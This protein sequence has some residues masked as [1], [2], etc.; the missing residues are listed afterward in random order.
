MAHVAATDLAF[1]HPGGDT[2][3]SGV[4]F[5]VSDGAHV[6]VVGANGVG[7]ST[8]FRVV[9]GLLPAADGDVRVGGELA[10]MPQDVGLGGARDGETV[11]ELLLAAAPA[12]VADAGRRMLAAER[13]LAADGGDA[14]AGMR[15]GEAMADWSELGGYE[16]EGRWDAAC[17]RIVRAGLDE[18]GPRPVHALSGG[19]RKQLVLELLLASEAQ[20][21]L[22]DEPDNFLDIPAKRWLEH[23]IAASKKTILLISHDRDLLGAVTTGVLTLEGHGCWMHG[24][25]FRTYA[26]AREHRQQ[27][28]GD[29]LARW[30]EEER[31]LFHYYKT[32][33][34]R[35]AI[36]EALARRADAAE[37]RWRR[38]VD[39]GPPPAPV[40]DQQIAVRL[41]G[42]DTARKALTFRDTGVDR[43]VEPFSDEVHFGERVALVGPNGSG[44]SHLLRLIA[45]EPIAHTGEAV[46][47]PR[48]SPGLFSQLNARPDFA[49]R[50]VLD[51]VEERTGAV[52]PAMRGLARYGLQDAARRRHD[53]LS[54]G[55]RARLEILCLELEGHTLLLLDEPT[56]NLDIDSAMALEAALERFEGTVLAVS[57]DR[58]FLRRMDR[59][60]LLDHDGAVHALPDPETTLAALEDP[61]AV[62]ALPLAKRLSPSTASAARRATAPRGR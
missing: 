41:R 42:G 54:G 57:H 29:R 28:L 3:F 47:G 48:V 1:A 16:L 33:K 44:K 62:G 24:A 26:E 34:Q 5:R 8:M 21:L 58:A 27:L 61:R 32:M 18:V 50:G 37:T 22:L 39:N 53:Q 13:D 35:A 19:E 49:G 10:Y 59:A 45:G 9:A 51:I 2:L 38:F 52:E 55:Q 20:V 36:S 12:R 6:G 60:L 11:R 7:K 56:D 17:R 25:S 40:V 15:L 30:K 31:R 43:L 46:L 23:R 4:S 14:D